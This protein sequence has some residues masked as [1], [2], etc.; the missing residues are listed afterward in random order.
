MLDFLRSTPAQVVIWIT[1]LSVVCTIGV[2]VIKR[3]RE[4]G[5]EGRASA[6]DLLTRFREMQDG[7]QIS[8]IEFRKIRS[9]L[10]PR[11]QDQDQD[12]KFPAKSPQEKTPESKDA[13]GDG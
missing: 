5:T 6:S 4:Q 7:G 11:I 10:G 2:Y 13:E 3:F 1:V 8:D 9:V 12:K